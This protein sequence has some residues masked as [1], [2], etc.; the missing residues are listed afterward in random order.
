MRTISSLVKVGNKVEIGFIRVLKVEM[1]HDIGFYVFRR[2]KNS[3][4]IGFMCLRGH[5]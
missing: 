5:N 4:N 1:R 3:Q 2:S